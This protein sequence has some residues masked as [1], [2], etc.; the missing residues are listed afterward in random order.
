MYESDLF[1]NE[2]IANQALFLN[3][4][5]KGIL[6]FDLIDTETFEITKETINSQTIVKSVSNVH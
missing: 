3:P 2:A 1:A 6:M 5:D 4:D